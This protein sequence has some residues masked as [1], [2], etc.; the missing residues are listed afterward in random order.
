MVNWIHTCFYIY[1]CCFFITIFTYPLI[2]A[3]YFIKTGDCENI[4]FT[5]DVIPTIIDNTYKKLLK[6]IC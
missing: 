2:G 3:F 1:V 6:Y 4:P 5:P